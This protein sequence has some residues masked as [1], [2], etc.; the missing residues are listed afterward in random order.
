MRNLPEIHF[1]LSKKTNNGHISCLKRS[2]KNDR[3]NEE[4]EEETVERWSKKVE[5]NGGKEPKSKRPAL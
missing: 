2:G 3:L 5:K 1:I 4:E